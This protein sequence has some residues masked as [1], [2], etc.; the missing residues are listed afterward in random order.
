MTT[1]ERRIAIKEIRAAKK[2]EYGHDL[3]KYTWKQ[4]LCGILAG[5]G[6]A[7]YVAL[8]ATEPIVNIEALPLEGYTQEAS[9]WIKQVFLPKLRDFP[10]LWKAIKANNGLEHFVAILTSLIAGTG[11]WQTALKG[12]L[13]K[14]RDAETR[15]EIKGLGR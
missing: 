12:K 9:L 10:Q 1:E 6:I 14:Q 8:K 4:I 5:G 3:H 11:I 13:K 15:E 2:E 7:T